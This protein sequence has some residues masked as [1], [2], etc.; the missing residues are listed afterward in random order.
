VGTARPSSP[1]KDVGGGQDRS[2]LLHGAI[3]AG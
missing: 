1:G 2:I 3:V